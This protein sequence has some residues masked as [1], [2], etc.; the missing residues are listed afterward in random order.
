MRVM[1]GPEELS[2]G[3]ASGPLLCAHVVIRWAGEATR[4]RPREMWLS[5]G[6]TYHIDNVVGLVVSFAVVFSAFSVCQ[7]VH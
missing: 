7:D 3:N 5:V 6:I 1:S 2:Y 4:A